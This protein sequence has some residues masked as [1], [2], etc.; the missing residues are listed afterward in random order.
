MS[1]INGNDQQIINQNQEMLDSICRGDW[2]AYQRHCHDDLT[3][4]EAE[5]AGHLVEG[6]AFHRFYFPDSS[7]ESSNPSPSESPV[8]VTM[9][10]PHLRWIGADNV[11]LSYTRLTQRIVNGEAT[12]ST[13]CETRVWERRNKTWGQVHVHRS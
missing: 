9:V 4:F 3:C 6:L 11:I 10:R 7:I 2:E 12:T 8:T 1:D 13:C 5:T